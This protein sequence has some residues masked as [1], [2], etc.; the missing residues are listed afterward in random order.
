[1]TLADRDALRKQ[2]KTFYLTARRNGATPARAL[3]GAITLAGKLG[4]PNPEYLAQLAQNE[5]DPEEVT[6]RDDPTK[7]DE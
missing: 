1:M 7:G 2:V 4:A 6:N 5:I 3:K